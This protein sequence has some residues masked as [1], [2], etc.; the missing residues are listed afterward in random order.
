MGLKEMEIIE[1]LANKYNAIQFIS[2][3]LDETENSF[4][5]FLRTNQYKWEIGR[6]Q[7]PQDVIELFKLDHLPTYI[8]IDTDGV[9]V[10]YPAYTPSPLYNNQSIDV[11]FFNL[12]KK[13]DQRQRLRIGVKG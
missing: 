10:Q 7:N 4:A 5:N 11:T 3:N 9:I 13:L 8:F 12:Q 6:P 2:V 1:Q